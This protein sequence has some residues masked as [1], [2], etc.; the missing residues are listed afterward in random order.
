[1]ETWRARAQTLGVA[2]ITLIAC[3][4]KKAP[5]PAPACDLY[6]SPWFRLARA[7]AEPRGRW[8]VLSARYGLVRPGDILSP[9]DEMLPKNASAWAS[10]VAAQLA[11]NEVPGPVLVLAGS[12][13]A[14]PLVPLLK[15]DGFEPE[16]PLKGLG[17]GQQLAWLVANGGGR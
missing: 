12:R 11:D 2:V 7:V 15:E 10:R 14:G 9:Y 4:A 6:V 17:I 16:L 1:M 3:V 13:Y 8:Y 5:C